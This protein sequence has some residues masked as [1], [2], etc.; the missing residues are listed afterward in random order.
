MAY[1]WLNGNANQVA[2][3]GMGGSTETPYYGLWNMANNSTIFVA[4]EG[5]DMGWANSGGRDVTLTD[6]ILAEVEGDSS[7]ST[8]RACSP[9]ASATAPAC[10]SRSPARARLSSAPSCSTP[11]PRLSGCSGGTTPVAYFASHGGSDSVLN[12]S[13]GRQLRDKFVGLNGC[14]AMSPPEPAKGS[15]KHTCTSY[16][17]CSAGHPV[18]WCAFDGDH[19]PTQK[20]SGQSATRVPGEAWTFI[21]QF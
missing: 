4:P 17:G 5:L 18:R 19:N 1:H 20:D 14:T 9:R 11:V 2:N 21:T 7:A 8:R 3:G 10:L 15:G 13:K 12:I 6:A 16:Q